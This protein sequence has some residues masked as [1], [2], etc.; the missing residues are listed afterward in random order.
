MSTECTSTKT[1]LRRHPERGSFEPDVVHAILDEALICHVG[2]VHDGGPVVI[3]TIHARSGDTL[4]LH[5]SPASRMLRTLASGVDVSVTATLV[6]GLVLAKS[7]FHHSLNYRSVV[8]FGR[9]T[10]VTDD[11]AKYEALRVIVE[12]VQAGRSTEARPP[13]AKELAGTLVLAL[14]LE[15]CSA[16]IRTGGPIDDADDADYPVWTGVVDVGVRAKA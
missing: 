16:K 12:H 11:E 3:P 15:E 10:V 5:G 7:W 14:P 8:V 1:T 4:Y 6:D 9:T 13:N 2:F